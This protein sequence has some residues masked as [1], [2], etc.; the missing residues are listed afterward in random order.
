M[1]RLS[2]LVLFVLL[3]PVAVAHAEASQ[4]QD[5]P[6]TEDSVDQQ[7]SPELPP[8]EKPAQKTNKPEK[9]MFSDERE[10][11]LI[12]F[13]A[14]SVDFDKDKPYTRST[15]FRLEYRFGYSLLSASSS[16]MNFDIHPIAGIQVATNAQ[17]YGFGGFAF[18]WILFKHVVVTESE[19]VGFFDSAGAP[20][21]LGSFIEFRSEMEAGW[22]FDDGLRITAQCSHISNANLTQRNPGEETAGGYVHI[23]VRMLFGN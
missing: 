19:S 10:P 2:F 18:D 5:P 7:A 22:R 6:T 13:G 9:P 3:F 11:D 15:D 20:K 23:P 17:K 4:D 12:A 8:P 21:P 1:R 14:S 16:W